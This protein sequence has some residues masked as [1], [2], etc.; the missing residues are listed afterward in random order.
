[1]RA[2]VGVA[3]LWRTGPHAVW[4]WDPCPPWEGSVCAHLPW[5]TVQT[6]GSRPGGTPRWE[7]VTCCGVG[8][9]LTK[10]L[11]S[12]ETPGSVWGP[13]G[14]AALLPSMWA[15]LQKPGVVTVGFCSP[16]KRLALGDRGPPAP[17][18][19]AA[20]GPGT[21]GVRGEVLSRAVCLAHAHLSPS[22]SSPPRRPTQCVLHL[23]CRCPCP[24]C[25]RLGWLTGQPGRRAGSKDPWAL[26]PESA[27]GRG[28]ARPCGFGRMAGTGGKTWDCTF[29]SVGTGS[30]T[31]VATAGPAHCPAS[32]SEGAGECW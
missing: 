22:Q 25:C 19:A 15:A 4:P 30:V 1:M 21:A 16:A 13:G 18:G 10:S 8:G 29:L 14:P 26:P 28:A 12:G 2:G 24:A 31:A 23:L 5:G 20:P 27:L 6:A 7:S 9:K 32:G 17:P 11:V 3:Q